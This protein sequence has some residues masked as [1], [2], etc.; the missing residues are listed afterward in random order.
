MPRDT[1]KGIVL[2]SIGIYAT[3]ILFFKILLAILHHLKWLFFEKCC[4][5][6]KYDKVRVDK[7]KSFWLDSYKTYLRTVEENS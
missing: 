4:R 2:L 3:S 1:Q 5:R 7:L 6:I